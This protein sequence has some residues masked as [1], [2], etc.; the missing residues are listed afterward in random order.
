MDRSTRYSDFS[1]TTLVRNNDPRRSST[2]GNH[3]AIGMASM[4][5]PNINASSQSSSTVT[6]PEIIC[7]DL[8]EQLKQFTAQL[9]QYVM[10]CTTSLQ[11]RQDHWQTTLNEQRQRINQLDQEVKVQMEQHD[12]MTQALIKEQNEV[13]MMQSAVQQ[14]EQRQ[15]NE[16]ERNNQLNATI[17]ATERLVQQKRQWLAD[18]QRIMEIQR[19][20]NKLEQSCYET[21]LGLRI[22]SVKVDTIEFIF[23]LIDAQQPERCFQFT[24]SVANQ[25][26]AVTACE[27]SLSTMETMVQVLNEHRQFYTFLKQVRLAFVRSI[28]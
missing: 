19:E 1:S 5:L 26:Y 22:R 17:E 18:Q 10:H 20:K 2:I 3:G 9:D 6:A 23:N 14:L 8:R 7:D 27:P 4:A 16:S 15:L 21:M 11:T 13:Q 28:Q 12:K 24:L 25:V